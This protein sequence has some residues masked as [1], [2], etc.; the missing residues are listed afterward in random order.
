MTWCPPH[1]VLECPVP[2]PTEAVGQ[3]CGSK[4]ISSH[5]VGCRKGVCLFCRNSRLGGSS[6]SLSLPPHRVNGR[7]FAEIEITVTCSW[8]SVSLCLGENWGHFGHL[9][10]PCSSAQGEQRWEERGCQF[11]CQQWDAKA[12]LTHNRVP[13]GKCSC[14]E[15]DPAIPSSLWPWAAG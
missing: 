2:G 7:T 3:K 14:A 6:G 1:E 11:L 5:T 4:E 12:G 15:S 8:I 9:A 10:K 13:W